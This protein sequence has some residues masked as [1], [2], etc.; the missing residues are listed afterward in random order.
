MGRGER[1]ITI[2][3][4]RCTT[5]RT[6]KSNK[7]ATVFSDDSGSPITIFTRE[8]VRRILKSDLIFARPLPK[9]EEY[10]EYNEKP[11]NLLGFINVDDQVG[12]ETIK[13][14]RMVI[15][16]EGKK[17]L[18]GRDWLTQLNFIQSSRSKVR[19]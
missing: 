12:K 8:D 2:E 15:A 14:A 11:L 4:N 5:V 7:Q 9:N 3:W 1:S 10:C 6:K 17:S 19:K 13:K 18:V 16:R